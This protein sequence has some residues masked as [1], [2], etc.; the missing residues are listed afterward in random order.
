MAT[1]EANIEIYKDAKYVYVSIDGK[2][3]RMTPLMA[4]AMSEAVFKTACDVMSGYAPRE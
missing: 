3:A 1:A 2:T 4:R